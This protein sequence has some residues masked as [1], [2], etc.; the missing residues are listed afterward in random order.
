[1]PR[2]RN[3][4]SPRVAYQRNLRALLQFDHQFRRPRDFV[5]LVITHQ[6]FLNV[7]VR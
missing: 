5:V 6:L 3:S 2:I 1:M 7:E 4:G